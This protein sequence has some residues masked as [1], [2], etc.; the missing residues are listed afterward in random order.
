VTVSIGLAAF[1]QDAAEVEDLIGKADWALYQAKKIGKDRVC[2]FA[3]FH[4]S[5]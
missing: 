3:A 5:R 4:E 2:V 1:P